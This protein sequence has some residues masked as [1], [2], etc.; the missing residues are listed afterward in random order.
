MK[1]L[2]VYYCP[3]CGR[4]TFSQTTKT[5]ICPICGISMIRLTDYA[6]FCTLNKEERDRLLVQNMITEN[7]S[8]SSRFLT[9]TRFCAGSKASDL[10]DTYIRQLESENKELNNTIQWMHQMIWDL[11][12]KN[13]A[14]EHELE[15]HLPPCHFRQDPK[16]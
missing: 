1:D 15:N 2:S 10:Q 12:H 6:D 11:I 13:K 3:E 9:Y 7:P 5:I 8:V 14:L 4:Y 16:S